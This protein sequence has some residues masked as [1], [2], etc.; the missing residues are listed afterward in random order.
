M[1]KIGW[2][3]VTLLFAIP[4]AKLA[5]KITEQI[6]LALRPNDPPRD[7]GK[8]DTSWA[9]AIGWAAVSA[10]GLAAGR[11]IAA[12]GAARTWRT[13]FGQEPPGAKPAAKSADAVADAPR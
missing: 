8:S 1:N 13:L 7:P 4:I 6:W 10:I 3:I 2:K 12:R 11:L 5:T 9:D